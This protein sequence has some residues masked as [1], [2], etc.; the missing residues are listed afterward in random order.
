[1]RSNSLIFSALVLSSQALAFTLPNQTALKA[2]DC[3]E[4]INLSH[5]NLSTS[6]AIK[7][8]NLGQHNLHKQLSR[9]YQVTAT[10]KQLQKGVAIHTQASGAVIRISPTNPDK[11]LI[12]EFQIKAA[13]SAKLSLMDASSLFSKEEGL[14]ETAFAGTTLAIAQLKPELGS[15]E[16]I[17]SSSS[18][19]LAQTDG[20][21]TY[22]IH[23]FDS[24]ST[25]EL[26]IETDKA[27]YQFGDPLKS[28]ISLR[29]KN[30]SYS[31]DTIEVNLISPDGQKTTL[32][33]QR[34]NE[35]SY[36]ISYPLRSETND[37]GQN[38]YVSASV[39]GAAGKKTVSR[40][41]HSAFSYTIPSAALREL[42]RTSA[43]GFDFSA[44]IEVATESRYALQAVLFGSDGQGKLHPL[45]IVQSAA[46]LPTGLNKFDF[47]FDSN[48][49]SNYKEPFY[50]GYIRLTDFGQQKPVYF[51]DKPIELS[52]LG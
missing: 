6:W 51:Y 35:S 19:A 4:C 38:W 26:S 42:S 48:L 36:E 33:T 41:G 1:M 34:V 10:L 47:S 8:E 52:N 3:S 39:T 45:Q 44:K 11:K 28:T 13:N 43:K 5:D 2:Y 16:F 15:G 37:R 23:V 14:K 25:T 18:K 20:G 30:F 17:V 9:K 29:D 22:I 46:W 40:Q 7:D 50:L 12:P 49:K 31:I 24:N 21:S 32:P 27:H